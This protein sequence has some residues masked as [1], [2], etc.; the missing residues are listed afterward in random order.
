M[1]FF[2][3]FSFQKG[4]PEFIQLLWTKCCLGIESSLRPFDV[5]C[6]KV[7]ERVGDE[8]TVLPGFTF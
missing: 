3:L 6:I 5:F 1:G 2:S 8:V 7:G 4:I